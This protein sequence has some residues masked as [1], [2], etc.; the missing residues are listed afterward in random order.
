MILHIHTTTIIL[1]LIVRILDKINIVGLK[2]MLTSYHR[3]V[4]AIRQ[5]IR[6]ATEADVKLVETLSASIGQTN[7]ENKRPL[8]RRTTR[9][10]I[11]RPLKRRKRA[12]K[13]DQEQKHNPICIQTDMS[14]PEQHT[15]PLKR[16][17]DIQSDIRAATQ[18]IEI[19]NKPLRD[20]LLDSTPFLSE[21]LIMRQKNISTSEITCDFQRH[22]GCAVINHKKIDRIS[23]PSSCKI[24]KKTKS[25]R[26]IKKEASFVCTAC[27]NSERYG[28]VDG[29]DGIGHE[30]RMRLPSPPYTYKPLQHFIDLL[31]QVEGKTTRTVPIEVYEELQLR[32]KRMRMPSE[33]I[34]ASMVRQML[35]LIRKCKYYEDIYVITKRLNPSFKTIVIPEQRK[36]ILKNMFRQVYPRFKRNAQKVLVNR[37]NFLSYPYVAFKFCELCDWTMYM[38]AFN[39]LKSREKL[40]KQDLILQLIFNELQWEW[41]YT[42]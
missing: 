8:K 5:A 2:I 20:F 15:R 41:T 11:E 26:I 29:V 21:Y 31:N 32:F 1:L 27:G 23:V 40:R 37:K 36:N 19:A 30:D 17:L 7:Q 14:N 6:I 13:E 16:R 4:H 22:F 10:V 33:Q 39:L 12:T 18:R 3:R 42:V 28:I 25:I 34:D 24:C 38:H 9:A 35:R